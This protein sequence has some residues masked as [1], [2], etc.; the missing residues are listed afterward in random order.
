[1]RQNAP[2]PR[3]WENRI[4][5]AFPAETRERLDP[6]FEVIELQRG[7][8]IHAA[9]DPIEYI[10]FIEQGLVSVVKTM[11]DGRMVEVGT[12]G[13]EGMIGLSALIGIDHVLVDVVVQAPGIALRLRPNLMVDEMAQNHQLRNLALRYGHA[14]LLQFIQTAACNSLHSIEERYCRW[15]LIAHDSVRTASIPLTHE[16]L[17]ALLGVQ[18]ASVSVVA[19]AL[20]RAGV[21]EYRYGQVTILD[22]AELE[23]RACECYRAI[24]THLDQLLEA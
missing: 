6:G 9:G 16:F 2:E 19:G 10:Y 11:S 22:R 18:R 7:Q 13:K 17:A 24:R 5:A 20:Q 12:I 15:L 3:H 1:M 8:V 14:L 23:A 21:I 4:L